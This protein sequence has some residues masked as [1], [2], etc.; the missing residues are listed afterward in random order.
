MSTPDRTSAQENQSPWTFRVKNFRALDSLDW[1][2]SGVCLLGGPNGSGKTSVLNA[3]QFP[4]FLFSHD[5]TKALKTLGGATALRHLSAPDEAPVTFEFASGEICWKI[6]IPIEGVG[7]HPF[8]GEQ[9]TRGDIV[10]YE[11]RPY[12][13]TARIHGT[14]QDRHERRSGLHVLWTSVKPPWLHAFVTR[15]TQV[16]VHYSYD[17]NA[18][19]RPSASA[20]IGND[21]LHPTGRNLWAVLKAWEGSENAT[22]RA[23]L[24]WVIEQARRGFPD[25]IADLRFDG[26]NG[27]PRLYIPAHEDQGLPVHLAA[28]GLLVGLLHLTAVAGAPPGM[29]LGFDEMENQL[30]PHA[31]RSILAAMRERADEYDLTMVLTTHSPVLMNEFKGH[32]DSFFIL[33]RSI[34][35]APVPTPLSRVKD[36]KWLRHFSLGDLYEREEFGAPVIAST[37]PAQTIA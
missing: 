13:S 28:D 2:P 7:V 33:D 18:V 23:R 3:L 36:P 22:D 31:I 34:A 30:H 14:M 20:D 32:E 8:Y 29:L 15:L 19:I 10:E 5:L 11:A 24:E 26:S 16:R 25:I 6:E 12:E 37:S 1:S 17:L 4:R 27:E 21:Y 9:L 35:G